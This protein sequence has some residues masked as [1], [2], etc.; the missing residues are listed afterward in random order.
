[1]ENLFKSSTIPSSLLLLFC[2]P[3]QAKASSQPDEPVWLNPTIPVTERIESLL[4]AMTTEEKISQLL[5]DSPAIPRLDIPSYN[6]WNECLHGVARNGRA[7]VFPQAIGLAA[8]FNAELAE[9]VATAIS[10][11]ARAKFNLAQAMD[12]RSQYAGLTFWTPNIN[13][14]RDPRW[15]RG[16]ETYGE[17]PYLTGIMGTAIVQGLQGNDPNHLKTAACAKHFAVHSGPEA[18]RHEFDAVVSEKDLFETYLPAFEMLVVEGK[19]ESVMGAYNRVLG[20]PACGSNLLLKEILRDKWGFKGHVVSDCGAIAD[21]HKYHKITDTPEESAA[22]ALKAGTD[23]NCGKT[24]LALGKALEKGLVTEADID[25][26]LTNLLGTRFKLGMF[27]PKGSTPW[28]NLGAEVVESPAHV[29]L[30]REVA[31][32]SIVLLKNKNNALPLKKDI[33]NLFVTGPNANNCDILL[34]NYFGLSSKTVSILEGIVGRVSAGTTVN[35]KQGVLPFRENVNPIDWTTEEAK[36]SDAIIAVMGLSGLLEGEEGESLAS[37]NKGDRLQLGL[38][39]HQVDFLK[40]L[41]QD[42]DK[43][44][45]VVMTG[46]S[47]VAMPEVDELA[48]ALVWAW[49]PGQEGGNAVADILFGDINPSGRLPITFPMSEA[50]LPPYEDY[51]MSGRTYR[52]MK[53]KPLYPFG[54]GLS[55]TQ[56]SYAM[57]EVE[58]LKVQ[59]SGGIEVKT[60]VTNIGER[61][62]NE[63]V[64]LYLSVPHAGKGHPIASLRGVKQI[65][66]KAGESASVS[67]TVTPKMMSS[68]TNQGESVLQKGTYQIAVG[69]ASPNER[70]TELLG[71]ELSKVS[72]VVK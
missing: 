30:A 37:E 24:Y 60:T 44:L 43:P 48:D 5:N 62:G 53:E 10:D 9:R 69:G 18:D 61:A 68:I 22:W 26:A 49:Y 72:Y 46:G 3:S 65:D 52:Y 19:V 64:Q 11:E 32:K 16:Q 21:F 39:K 47:P 4:N 17:D 8:T 56:F 35:Y 51:D 57:P 66:L 12:N 33:R 25:K 38:M 14:F 70:T 45:I 50:Q 15:G 13:I 6:W 41:R 59:Q 27:D 40:K 34:G 23:L 31:Q 2:I 28:D 36:A 29:A 67:F 58:P 54:Y 20:D 7:T 42:N 1:M 55:F 63:V 71:K